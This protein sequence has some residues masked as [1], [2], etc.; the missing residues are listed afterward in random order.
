VNKGK[1][2][3]W[4]VKEGEKE[5]RIRDEEEMRKKTTGKET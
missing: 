2:M 4:K 5:K 3:R 1:E